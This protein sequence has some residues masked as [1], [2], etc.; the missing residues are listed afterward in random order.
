MLWNKVKVYFKYFCYVKILKFGAPFFKFGQGPEFQETALPPRKRAA[1]DR[2]TGGEKTRDAADTTSAST[3]LGSSRTRRPRPSTTTR[4]SRAAQRR[5]PHA[6]A[7]VKRSARIWSGSRPP[8][9]SDICI[10]HRRGE[11]S[12]HCRPPQ[13]STTTSDRT[14]TGRRAQILALNL[15]QKNICMKL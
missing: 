3:K 7:Q 15:V 10:D 1:A 8:E 6:Q 11:R 14:T 9:T 5:P 2:W 12:P 4:A 13:P